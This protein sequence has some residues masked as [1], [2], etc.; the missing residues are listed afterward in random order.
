MVKKSDSWTSLWK[1]GVVTVPRHSLPCARDR[2]FQG[3]DICAQ[4]RAIV[5]LTVLEQFRFGTGLLPFFEL[6]TEVIPGTTL[7]LAQ[8]SLH[9]GQPLAGEQQGRARRWELLQPSDFHLFLWLN[10][11]PDHKGQLFVSKV[12]RHCSL[13]ITRIW[14]V[15]ALWSNLSSWIIATHQTPNLL[16]SFPEKRCFPRLSR[17]VVLKTSKI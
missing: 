12:Y 10:I 13:D 15:W 11:L 4:P 17:V 16:N 6:Q 7:L 8:R 14:W 2:F 1:D 3:K 5:G 9:E